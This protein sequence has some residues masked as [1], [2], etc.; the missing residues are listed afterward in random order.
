LIRYLFDTNTCIALLNRRSPSLAAR[1]RRHRPSE[2]ALPAMVVYELYFGAFKSRQRDRNIDLLD[3]ILLEIVPFDAGD[4]RMA[5]SVRAGLEA[6]GRPIGPIDT[7][8][9]GQA[10]ARNLTLVTAN[11]REFH[12]VEGLRCED[13]SVPGK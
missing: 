3:R 7:L 11:T 13:W 12:R 5:G 9:A 6:I 4:A 1:V 8:I 2:I 10:L